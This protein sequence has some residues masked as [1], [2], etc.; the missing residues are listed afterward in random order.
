MYRHSGGRQIPSLRRSHPDPVVLLHPHTASRL[1]ISE[2]DWVFIE[3]RQGRIK[4][5]A[6]LLR[7]LDPRVVVVD[8]AWWFPE[9]GE[10]LFGFVDSSYNVL[11]SDEPPFSREIGSFVIRGLACRISRQ[12]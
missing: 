1:G 7:G 3:T 5:K 4:Q 9:R 8:H 12:P 10:E 2:G 11:T 6:S